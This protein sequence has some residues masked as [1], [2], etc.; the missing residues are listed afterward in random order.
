MENIFFDIALLIIVASLIALLARLLKQ[1][2]IPAYVLAGLFLAPHFSWSIAGYIS[3]LGFPVLTNPTL[4]ATLSEIGIAFLL[5]IVGLEIN[6]KL[7]R[8]VSLVT[9][10]GG[11]IKT[12]IMYLL[13]WLL[14]PYFGFSSIEALY[15]G[16]ALSFSST[17]VVVKLFSDKREL[18]ALHSRIVVGILLVEDIIVIFVLSFLTTLST[19]SSFI[20]LVALLKAAFLF[21]IVSLCSMILFPPLFRFAARTPELLFLIALSMCFLFSLLANFLGFSIAIGAFLAGLALGTLPYSYEIIGRITPLR[22]F[23]TILFFVSLGMQLN[24]GSISSLI[25]PFLIFTAIIVLFKPLLIF[26]LTI[27]FG[28]K[29]RTAFLSGIALCQISEFSLILVALGKG[30]GV[31]DDGLFT[32]VTLLAIV[33][34]VITTYAVKYDQQLYLFFSPILRYFDKI[35]FLEKELEYLPQKGTREVVLVGY[36][37][38]GYA[39]FQKLKSLRKATLIVDFNP[40]VIRHL[41]AKKVPCLYGDVADPEILHRIHLK[42]VKLL[43]STATDMHANMLLIRQAKSLHPEVVVFVTAQQV[44]EALLLYEAGADYVIL[45]HFL[46]GDHVSLILEEVSTD[47]KKI[48]HKKVKHIKELHHRRKLGHDQ[49]RGGFQ[50]F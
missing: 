17:M 13:V 46:G 26:I 9:V 3:Q 19:F 37:R 50:F 34:I 14:A 25:I 8:D 29:K 15:L 31:V 24:L 21:A 49:E 40:E 22:D 28:Y 36:H 47:F 23:F 2:L 44:D 6:L 11:I 1:P 10:L 20:F 39:L 35:A 33:T 5:F 7:L 42:Q 16:L 43:I 41:V 30:L 18:D 32:L 27:L 38:I 12:G 48:L 45:P 4:I